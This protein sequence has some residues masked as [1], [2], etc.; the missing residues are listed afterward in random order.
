M[1]FKTSLISSASFWLSSST[2]TLKLNRNSC[3]FLYLDCSLPASM[4]KLS[5]ISFNSSF[6]P[7]SIT[8]FLSTSPPISS[9]V[10]SL[11]SSTCSFMTDILVDAFSKLFSSPKPSSFLSLVASFKLLVL[12]S[13]NPKLLNISSKFSDVDDFHWLILST[14]NALN[15]IISFFVLPS[16]SNSLP[17]IPWLSIKSTTYLALPN[18]CLLLLRLIPKASLNL[19]NS[20]I[21]LIFNSLNWLNPPTEAIFFI[22]AASDSVI[23]LNL[24]F[25]PSSNSLIFSNSSFVTSSNLS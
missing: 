18:S 8:S 19:I 5:T 20:F 4:P 3:N 9:L 10:S 17:L 6:N 23:L 21:S 2:F 25:R 11:K 16:S 15:K 12:F 1:L 24:P 14:F 7:K 22:L 13:S